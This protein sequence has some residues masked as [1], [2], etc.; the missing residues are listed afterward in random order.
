MGKQK[1]QQGTISWSRTCYSIDLA[2]AGPIAVRATR[3]RGGVTCTGIDPADP[4]VRGSLEGSTMVAG[5]LAEREGFSRWLTAPFRSERKSKQVLPSMLDIQL[6]FPLEDCTYMFLPGGITADGKTLALAVAARTAEIRKKL[7]AYTRIGADPVT[8]DQEGIALWTQSILEIPVEKEATRVVVSLSKNFATISLGKGNQFIASHSVR[9]GAENIVRILRTRLGTPPQALEWAWT[10]PGATPENV[11]AIFPSLLQ[12]WPGKSL[13]HKDPRAF[14]ARAIA[15]RAL[16]AGPLRCNL[17]RGEFEHR[18]IAARKQ[19]QHLT[20]SL[21]I[22]AAGL[23]LAATSLA[24]GTLAGRRLTQAQADFSRQVDRLAGYHVAEKGEK[25]L[26]KVRKAQKARLMVNRPFDEAFEPSLVSTLVTILNVGKENNLT[27]TIL[28]LGKDKNTLNITGA[29]AT[30]NQ[31]EKLSQRLRDLG[32][33]VRS[34]RKET[35]DGRIY[36]T[37][38]R[39]GPNDRT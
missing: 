4:A 14:L 1:Q 7:D 30:W 26:A 19:R 8:L 20:T 38:V 36:F 11:E 24:T 31:C 39:G 9:Q 2:E 3:T 10:G 18:A 12:D 29:C 21:I 32:Y 37:I 6:P 17:R 25:A 22:L 15:T 23:I 35:S 33:A 13:Y 27:F 28:E 34:D 16:S 5:C